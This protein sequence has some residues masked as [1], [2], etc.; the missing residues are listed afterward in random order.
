MTPGTAGNCTPCIPQSNYILCENLFPFRSLN[1]YH[2]FW[3]F[4]HDAT[5]FVQMWHPLPV[6]HSLNNPNLPTSYPDHFSP[7]HDHCCFPWHSAL[8]LVMG[9]PTM[10]MSPHLLSAC[11]LQISTSG[12]SLLLYPQLYSELPIGTPRSL[13]QVHI[14]FLR[15]QTDG[16]LSITTCLQKFLASHDS[17]SLFLFPYYPT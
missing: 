9:K 1:L 10:H 2:L 3:A 7:Y 17:S 16:D 14:V 4:H 12:R 13:S 6:P 15:I 8:F 5:H 11:S